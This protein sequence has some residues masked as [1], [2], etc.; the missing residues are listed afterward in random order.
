MLKIPCQIVVHHTCDP[1]SVL[2]D[3][4]KTKQYLDWKASY[5]LEDIILSDYRWRVKEGKNILE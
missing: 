4:S 3:A 5:S 2:A 1:A